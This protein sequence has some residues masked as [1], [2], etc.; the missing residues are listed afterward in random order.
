[1]RERQIMGD[2]FVDARQLMNNGIDVFIFLVA[3]V[4]ELEREAEANYLVRQRH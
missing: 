4:K 2:G 3:D 1:M